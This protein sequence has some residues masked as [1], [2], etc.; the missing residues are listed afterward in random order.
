M[1]SMRPEVSYNL[2]SR[3]TIPV[4]LKKPPLH[5]MLKMRFG[6]EPDVEVYMP[7]V[8]PVNS[9]SSQNGAIMLLAADAGRHVFENAVLALENCRLPFD[10]ALTL[11]NVAP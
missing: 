10:I 7:S 5:S 9:R 1:K 2:A 3:S 11:L 4:P 6:A 8:A